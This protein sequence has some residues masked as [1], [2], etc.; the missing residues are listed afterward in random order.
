MIG[1]L[2]FLPD[3]VSYF[4]IYLDKIR[5]LLDGE[6]CLAPLDGQGWEESKEKKDHIVLGKRC[7]GITHSYPCPLP[8]F[9][10]ISKSK[11]GQKM[12]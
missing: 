7:R 6:W 2:H 4:E 5:D 9:T 3:Q 8:P 11:K 12:S 10:K 1:P